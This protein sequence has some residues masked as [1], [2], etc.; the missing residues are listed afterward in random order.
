MF[1]LRLQ[2]NKENKENKSLFSLFSLFTFPGVQKDG[3]YRK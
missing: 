3:I 1:F 2:E